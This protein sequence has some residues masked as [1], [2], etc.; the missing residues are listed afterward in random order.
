MNRREV[1]G[2]LAAMGVVGPKAFAQFLERPE[3]IYDLPPYGD[4]TLLYLS[5]LHA[6]L[7]PHYYME[8][9]NLIPPKPLMG[10]PG[11]L[12]GEAILRYYGLKPGSLEAYLASFVDFEA[13]AERFGP[14]GGGAQ[15]AALIRAQKDRA[16]KALVLDGGD[17]WTNSGISLLTRGEAVVEWMNRVGFDHM[18]SHWEWTLGRERVEELLGRLKAQFLSFNIR[19]ELFGDPL[20][21]E[22][23]IHQAG[24]YTVAILGSSYPYTRVAHPEAFT[25]GLSFGVREKELAQLVERLRGEG[26]DA[27]ILLSHNGLPL[28]TALAQRVPGIDLILTGHTHDLT[29][30]PLRVGRTYIVAGSTA[31]KA[32]VR[33]D[34]RLKRGGIASLRL[35]VLPVAS[36]VLPEDPEV[37]A[38]LDEAFRPHEAYLSEPLALSETLLYKRDTLYSTF[39]ELAGRAMEAYYGVEVAFSPGTRWGTTVLPGQAITRDHLLAF[40]GFTYPEV[41]VFRLKGGQIKALLEDV[42]AN[43]LSP[44][45]FY[46]QGGDLTRTYGLTYTLDPDAP[47]GQRIQDLKVRGQPLDPGRA[48]LCAA[49]GGRLQRLGTPVEGVEPKPIYEVMEAYL[50]GLGRVELPPRP[51]VRVV[52]RNYR[53]PE[54]RG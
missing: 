6:Q 24:G 1:L 40:T 51:N 30:T 20:F 52:G 33:V 42:A 7:R 13:L 37:K 32:L 22:Y 34:L 23:A 16:K 35:R 2:W 29:F 54:V 36:R 27:I 4:L 21:P 41:Y 28:D 53:I 5:D 14:L 45:P 31:G 12:T 17:T 8:P 9:P 15:I 49:Y 46:Q 48:Y 25:E 50:R 18:V 19:D 39:D 10:R 3:A 26:V 44:D 43:V 38:F 11:Y 47:L